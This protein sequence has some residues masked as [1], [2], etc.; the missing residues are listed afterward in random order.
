MATGIGDSGFFSN[1]ASEK[2]KA[3]KREHKQLF[4]YLEEVNAHAHRYRGLWRIKS[5]HLKGLFAAAL[6]HRALTAY[7]ALILLAQ[8]GFASEARAT[9]R[10]ILEA[11]FKLAFLFVEPEAA[12]LLIAA[13][14][15]KRADRLRS[16]KSGDLPVPEALKNQD[17]DAVIAKAEE[18]LKDAKGVKRKLPSMRDIAE[19]CG[20]EQDYLGY[21]SLFSEATHSGHI[22]LDGYLKF[23][24]EGTAVE[25]LLY[26]PEDGDWVDLVTLQGA[27]YLIDC[28]EI[29]ARIFGIRTRRD[30]EL[31]FKPLLRRNDEMIQRFRHLFLESHVEKQPSGR[32]L[33]RK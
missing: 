2:G 19:K 31:L 7:Q 11:K 5:R 21:Y 6:F 18:H 16:M 9:C 22:E 4:F 20:L 29:S 12:V 14:E 26:G 8:K 32:S 24:A 30:F 23:N 25:T 1:E 27:S 28:M 10:N 13:G 17:W 3:I 33:S 15:K